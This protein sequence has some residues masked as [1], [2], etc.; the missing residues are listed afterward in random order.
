MDGQTTSTKK[1]EKPENLVLLNVQTKG[2]SPT[3][4]LIIMMIIIV[5]MTLNSI[6]MY[7]FFFSSIFSNR[8]LSKA[9]VIG[10]WLK[11]VLRQFSCFAFR[12]EPNKTEKKLVLQQF[13][14]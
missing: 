3:R 11:N 6:S 1:T 8:W 12:G 2:N 4:A 9:T 7:F 14:R 13:F 5:E 10:M